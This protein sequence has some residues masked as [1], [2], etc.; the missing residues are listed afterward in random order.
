MD[1]VRFKQ[2]IKG[3]FTAYVDKSLGEIHKLSI[4][5]KNNGHS[6]NYIDHMIK[7]K[8]QELRNKHRKTNDD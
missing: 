4:D 3:E 7:I 2:T 6:E 8:M 1:K 5:L